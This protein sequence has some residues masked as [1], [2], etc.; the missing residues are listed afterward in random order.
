MKTI[1][2]TGGLKSIVDDEDYEKLKNF[3]WRC[4]RIHSLR[5][6]VSG[7][8]EKTVLMHRLILE[9]KDGVLTD[10]RNGNGLDNRKENLRSCTHAQNMMSRKIHKNN[11]S[12][13]RGVYWYV[14][15][16]RWRSEIRFCGRKIYLGLHR[17]RDK[18]AISYD[19]AAKK[20]FGSFARLNFN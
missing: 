18:A 20:Y 5:Y 13:F 7:S 10:H 6:A 2:L 4:Q 11:K 16:R 19:N 14:Q 1:E 9:Q 3:K 12:G 15:K 8:K 17:D